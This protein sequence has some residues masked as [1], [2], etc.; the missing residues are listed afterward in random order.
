[1]DP[2]MQSYMKAS[3]SSGKYYTIPMYTSFYN[4]V[5]DVDLFENDRKPLYFAEDGT[6]TSG[7]TE[8]GAKAKSAGQ[9]GVAGTCR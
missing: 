6:F 5:Y 4:I 8:S 1:M 3:N 7:K 2:F 9:D